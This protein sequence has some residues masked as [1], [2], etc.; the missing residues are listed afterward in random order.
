MKSHSHK[1]SGMM[2]NYMPKANEKDPVVKLAH[3]V[4]SSF[5][6][7]TGLEYGRPI[8]STSLGGK[9]FMCEW[10]NKG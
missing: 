7:H 2:G 8:F 6:T 1:Q 3:T 5:H 10:R 4:D 9:I